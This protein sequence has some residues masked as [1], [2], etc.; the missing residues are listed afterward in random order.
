MA[1]VTNKLHEVLVLGEEPTRLTSKDESVKITKDPR[2]EIYDLSVEDTLKDYATKEELEG[3]QDALIEGTGI[4][5]ENNVISVVSGQG[6]QEVSHDNTLVGKGVEDNKLGVNTDVIATKDDI[7]DFVTDDDL[8]DYAKKED[9]PDVSNF[10]T[11]D[12][13]PD[14]SNFPTKGEVASEYQPKGDYALV[15][16]SY[17]KKESDEKYALKGD[18]PTDVYTKGEADNKFQEKGDYVTPSDLKD[19]ATKD[20]IPDSYTKQ[21]SDDKYQEKGDYVESSTLN[22]YYTKTEIENNYYTKD[23]VDGEFAT[24]DDIPDV[25]NFATKDEIPDVSGLATKEDLGGKQDTLVSGENIKT[26]N[27]ESILG[28]GN[29]EI[30]GGGMSTVAT[31]D[32]IDGDGSAENPLSVNVDNLGIEFPTET[33]GFVADAPLKFYEDDEGRVHIANEGGSGA[34]ETDNTLIGNGSSDF[35]LGVDTSKFATKED[36]GDMLT[37]DIADSLYQPIGDYVEGSTLNNYY[38]KTE[39]ENNYAEKSEIVDAYTKTES[40]ERYALKGE[41][42]T[43]VYTKSE[44]DNKFATKEEIPDVSG[45]ATKDEIPDS[46]TKTESDNKYALKGE[47]GGLD[48]VYHNETLTGE[49]T[50]DNQLSVASIPLVAGENISIDKVGDEIVISS[51]GGSTPIDAYTKE[52]S[53][54]KYQE[55]GDYALVGD[56]YTKSESDNKYAL[57]DDVPSD[58]YTKSEA[59]ERFQEKGNYATKEELGGKQDTLIEGDNITIINNEISAHIPTKP[60]FAG[61]NIIIDEDDTTITINAIDTGSDYEAGSN[62]SIDDNVISCTIDL[63]SKQDTLVEGVGIKIEGNVISTDV[64]EIPNGVEVEGVN[65]VIINDSINKVSIGLNLATNEDIE[66]LFE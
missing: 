20:E 10:A 46:Y 53:D 19:Y 24:K 54:A 1:L 12:E 9:I 45:F 51:Q 33:V 28:S 62:I 63:D 66:A 39:I 58:V 26:I 23:D 16:D 49:G 30:Q 15:G 29:I 2:G 31:D 43:D 60:V 27:G 47:V 59:D 37:K 65:G 22:N 57:K 55:K 48:K 5:I 40:D 8:E 64:G 61:S 21:E 50:Q 36:I 52:E 41:A 13:I 11:K 18:V 34:I 42:P 25:S 4:K 17:T 32:T 35:P 38:T 44:V 56:S 3:K 14:V 7:K 6:L